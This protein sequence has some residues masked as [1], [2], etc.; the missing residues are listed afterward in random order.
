MTDHNFA[1]L[2]EKI[3]SVIA[4]PASRLTPDMTVSDLALDSMT[5]VELVVDLQED[6]DILLSREDFAAVRTL[7]D[8]AELVFSRVSGPSGQ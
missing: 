6:Y 5:T 1:E 8:L 2:T 7:G 4:L 3:A